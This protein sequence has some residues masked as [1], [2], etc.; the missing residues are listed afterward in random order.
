MR[1]TYT[2]GNIVVSQ[3][4]GETVSESQDN[5]RELKDN[6]KSSSTWQRLFFVAV[7]LLAVCVVLDM[8]FFALVILQCGFVL[9]TGK[10]NAN[11][12]QF[13][14]T[15]VRYYMQVLEYLS[16]KSDKRPFPFSDWPAN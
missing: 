1:H 12:L 8:V 5:I 7:F 14:A 6:V 11:L 13:T 9:L 16:F 4:K 2:V 10:K 3:T 15:V